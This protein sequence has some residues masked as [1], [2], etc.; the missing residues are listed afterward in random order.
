[1]VGGEALVLAGTEYAVRSGNLGPP[2]QFHCLKSSHTY[3][4][5]PLLHSSP[6]TLDQGERG[7]LEQCDLKLATHC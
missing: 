7:L 1:M 3:V 6:C 5:I 4:D 2:R